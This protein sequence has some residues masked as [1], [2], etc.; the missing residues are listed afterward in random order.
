[1]MK[2]R[3]FDHIDL[4]VGDMA[5]AEKFYGESPPA[6]GFKDASGDEEWRTYQSPGEGPEEFF[7]FT[8]GSEHLPNENRIAFWTESLGEVDW[9]TEIVRRAGGRKLEGPEF[10]QG[11]SPGYHAVFFED[12]NGNKFEICCR[13]SR[14]S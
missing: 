11:Y 10:C 12:P 7:G 2:L 8:K 3:R 1:M 14:P 9:L 5:A 6:P 4:R 13:E